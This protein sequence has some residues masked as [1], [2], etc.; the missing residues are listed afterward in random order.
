MSRIQPLRHLY[1]SAISD[2]TSSG[3]DWQHYLHFAASIYKY[4]FEGS[5][6]EIEKFA[7]AVRGH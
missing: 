7:E 1:A 4:S 3:N 2:I 6:T 5:I